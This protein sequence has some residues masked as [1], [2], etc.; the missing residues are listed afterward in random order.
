MTTTLFVEQMLR[1]MNGQR[2]LRIYGG[3]NGKLE[4]GI[5]FTQEMAPIM[6]GLFG[7]VGEVMPDHAARALAIQGF[8]LDAE[9]EGVSTGS[10]WDGVKDFMSF[11]LGV[12]R[13]PQVL[14][15]TVVTIG[16]GGS[17]KP[18]GI[19]LVSYIIPTLQILRKLKAFGIPLPRLRILFAQ[20]AAVRINGYKQELVFG[21]T[22]RNIKLL[23]LFILRFFPEIQDRVFFDCDNDNEDAWSVVRDLESSMSG[24][25]VMQDGHGLKEVF[26]A[27]KDLPRKN[28][29][30]QYAAVHAL[31]FGDIFLK[32][33]GISPWTSSLSTGHEEYV[34]ISIGGP[35]ERWFN[36]ARSFASENV[37]KGAIRSSGV[38]RLITGIGQ[39]PVYYPVAGEVLFGQRD[40][41][42]RLGEANQWLNLEKGDPARAAD[43]RVIRET[44]GVG[45]Y[46]KWV[47]EV[48]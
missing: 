33:G 43:Y 27:L 12:G 26:E 2:N 4:K 11:F 45:E 17:D 25:T 1:A 42:T 36:A 7:D 40:S 48:V 21:Q 29:M 5:S 20:T 31:L 16:Y 47:M 18:P 19:R 23:Q 13:N 6:A 8:F 30:G 35:T 15:K 3:P 22:E 24:V 28:M 34:G 37:P 41:L 32:Q 39:K 38:L 10:T 14:E 44:L 46:L 9:I